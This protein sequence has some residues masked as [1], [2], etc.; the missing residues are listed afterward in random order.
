MGAED[1]DQVNH[2]L[3]LE[4]LLHPPCL[5]SGVLSLT[6]SKMAATEC[7]EF[8]TK[9]WHSGSLLL[10]GKGRGSKNTL[11]LIGFNTYPKTLEEFD[12]EEQRLAT[13]MVTKKDL[14]RVR[15]RLPG[16]AVIETALTE[17]LGQRFGGAF[18]LWRAHVLRQ[19]PHTL[20]STGFSI[21]RDTVENKL[22]KYTVVVKLTFDE[23]GEAPSW[24]RVVGAP[25]SFQYGPEAGAC[26]CFLADLYHKSVRWT[27]TREHL[28]IAFFFFT[29]GGERRGKE[30]VDVV[31]GEGGCRGGAAGGGGGGGEEGVKRRKRGAVG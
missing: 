18:E 19:G 7:A 22:I 24:M 1:K 31:G 5:S 20:R 6:V 25:S 14:L 16:F 23:E 21:H 26:G 12:M 9:H 3:S 2:N 4:C 29:K 13:L 30:G 11:K 17:W 8:L 28:K 15:E 10:C 27:S